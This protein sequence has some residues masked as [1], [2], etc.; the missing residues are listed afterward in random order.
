LRDDT[1]CDFGAAGLPDIGTPRDGVTP[2]VTAVPLAPAASAFRAG[3]AVET[4]GIG[5]RAPSLTAERS[6]PTPYI[7]ITYLTAGRG[8]RLRHAEG[9]L[10]HAFIAEVG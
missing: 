10:L 8:G 4:N 6:R 2:G 5:Y 3:N 7:G 9:T 1:N